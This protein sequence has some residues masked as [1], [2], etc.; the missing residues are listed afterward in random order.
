MNSFLLYN[1]LYNTLAVLAY[2][3]KYRVRTDG[4][5]GKACI[6]SYFAPEYAAVCKELT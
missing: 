1:I 6:L 5:H 2:M 4:K 3:K